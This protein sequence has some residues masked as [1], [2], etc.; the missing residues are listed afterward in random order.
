MKYL[1]KQRLPNYIEHAPNDL[2]SAEV[3]YLSDIHQFAVMHFHHLRGETSHL[4]T[5]PDSFET[6]GHSY[7]LYVYDPAKLQ[8]FQDCIWVARVY[9]IKDE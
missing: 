7:N 4:F 2:E 5:T 8:S 1:V 9:E 3:D 6:A